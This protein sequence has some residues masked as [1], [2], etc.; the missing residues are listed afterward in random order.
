MGLLLL[1]K[2]ESGKLINVIKVCPVVGL[3]ST[4]VEDVRKVE[5]IRLNWSLVNLVLFISQYVT[6]LHVGDASGVVKMAGAG[7]TVADLLLLFHE[8]EEGR[9]VNAYFA[10]RSLEFFH[11]G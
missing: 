9:Y 1:R 8:L 2:I 11:G 10:H 3:A 7:L 5:F 6:S 4:H